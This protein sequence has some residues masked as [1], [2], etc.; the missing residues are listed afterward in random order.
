MTRVLLTIIL[1]LILPTALY[2]LW[3]VSAGRA[4]AASEAAPWRDLPWVWLGV[5]GAVLVV[6]MIAAV[7]EIGGTKDG[8]YVPPH[9]GNGDIVPGH[10]EPAPGH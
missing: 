3:V 4:G 2:V 5:A 7:V 1:P 8:I 9:L 10:V 6:A